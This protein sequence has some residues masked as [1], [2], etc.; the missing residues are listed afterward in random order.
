MSTNFENAE[1]KCTIK[2]KSRHVKPH[3]G[4][5]GHARQES[6]VLEETD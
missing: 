1:K 6:R 2:K 5:L 4:Q 3:N